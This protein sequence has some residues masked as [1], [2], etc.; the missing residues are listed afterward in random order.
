[1]VTSTL[2]KINFL[3]SL[4]THV[5]F[6]FHLFQENLSILEFRMAIEMN[7]TWTVSKWT[8]SANREEWRAQN[9]ELWMHGERTVIASSVHAN[10]LLPHG[11]WMVS[12]HKIG[13]V[14]R[15]RDCTRKY[16]FLLKLHKKSC[17]SYLQ[18]RKTLLYLW[19]WTRQTGIVKISS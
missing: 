16:L 6:L 3:L 15:F 19:S 1:M 7:Q 11:E 5:H 18:K 12:E 13:K 8:L 17:K 14:E 10:A 2:Y 9:C 4:R